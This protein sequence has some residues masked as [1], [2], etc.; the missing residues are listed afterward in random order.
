MKR[1]M[2]GGSLAIILLISFILGVSGVVTL[3]GTQNTFPGKLNAPKDRLIGV[4]LT[5][6]YL[7]LFDFDSY[8]KENANKILSG[9]E[10]SAEDS[11][12]YGERMY[13]TL[14]DRTGT[15]TK[16]QEYVFEGL[17]GIRFFAPKIKD[18][19]GIYWGNCTD[20]E[21]SATVMTSY[22]G[23][24]EM[25]TLELEGT[26]Y[27]ALTKETA[28]I[29]HIGFYVNPVYQ[30]PEGEVYLTAGNGI[31]HSGDISEGASF[32]QEIK[33]EKTESK[34]ENGEETENNT[35]G[36]VVKISLE[37]QCVPDKIKIVQMAANNTVL[38]CE[39]YIP[40]T[41]PETLT[42]EIG[43]DYIIVET[44]KTGSDGKPCV[45]RGFFQK[46]DFGFETKECPDGKYLIGHYTEIKW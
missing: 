29:D 11:A 19:E 39:E 46:E 5:E 2:I 18:D 8:F 20:D 21:V 9:G 42:P 6:E 24:N 45:E 23:D 15:E 44:Y 26:V 32:S 17:E 31:F 4:L 36:S 27:L 22:S 7:D 14:V 40:G 12:K 28:K 30:T 34:T 35:T 37:Y 41:L 25:V 13:A 3:A 38:S 1:K 33:E 43:T 16:R 10:I